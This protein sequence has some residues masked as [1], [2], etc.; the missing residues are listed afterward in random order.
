MTSAP[1]PLLAE[2]PLPSE[3]VASH[4]PPRGHVPEGWLERPLPGLTFAD[5]ICRILD[6]P[7]IQ[8]LGGPTDAYSL[9]S[10]GSVLERHPP[11]G[12]LPDERDGRHAPPGACRLSIPPPDANQASRSHRADLDR[13][14]RGWSIPAGSPTLVQ[15]DYEYPATAARLWRPAGYVQWD[16]EGKAWLRAQTG[17]M[18]TAMASDLDRPAQAL[19]PITLRDP[20]QARWTQAEHARRHATLQEG[21]AAGAIYQANLT[22]PFLGR[23]QRH[24]DQDAAIALALRASSPAPYAAW[25]RSGAQAIVSCSPECFL[26]QR[27]VH[28]ASDPIKG[29][30]PRI[31]GQEQ[32]RRAALAASAKDGAELAMII[33]LVRNDLGRV[34][35]AGS[36]AVSDPGSVMDLPYVHHRVASV[37]ARLRPGQGGAD[38][39]AACFPAGSIT[40]APKRS[41]MHLLAE[42]EAGARGPYCGAFGWWDDA[43]NMDL[44]V[45]IRTVVMDGDALRFDAGGGIVADSQ[46][47]DEW[48]ELHAKAATMAAACGGGR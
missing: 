46:A 24:R 10:W 34:A 42:V 45:A 1:P 9:L 12:G 3:G 18:L 37:T 22:M 28:I 16:A 17:E 23:L 44:A 41:A 32:A 20:M 38:A 21:I 29:T 43:G 13:H 31:P 39:V 2:P 11:A 33:D 27:G 7:S 35:A 30:T 47:Q 14:P 36:V 48:R 6:C 5:A 15:M 19:P 40:G 25:F 4:S 8:A 26:R